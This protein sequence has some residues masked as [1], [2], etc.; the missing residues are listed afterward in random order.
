MW[1]LAS[2]F[3]REEQIKYF[4]FSKYIYSFDDPD[5][6]SYFC[7][8]IKIHNSKYYEDHVLSL[9]FSHNL[10]SAHAIHNFLTHFHLH[11]VYEDKIYW[12]VPADKKVEY[13]DLF[14]HD[15]S[16]YANKVHRNKFF[17]LE[18]ISYLSDLA[19]FKERKYRHIKLRMTIWYHLHQAIS[20]SDIQSVELI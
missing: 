18:E 14:E 1:V 7:D 19:I 11:D 3:H 4:S 17:R 10:L 8:T 5:C 9:D 12:R 6:I 15:N 16:V 13:R 2:N 20:E